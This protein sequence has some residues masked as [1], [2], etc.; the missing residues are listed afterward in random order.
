MPSVATGA[1]TSPSSTR[2]L[3]WAF[4]GSMLPPRLFQKTRWLAALRAPLR[5][6]ID[7]AIVVCGGMEK[8]EASSPSAQVSC[9]LTLTFGPLEWQI[10][11]PAR[12]PSFHGKTYEYRPNELNIG[13]LTVLLGKTSMVPAIEP[14]YLGGM[15][16]VC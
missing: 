4:D 15:A 6:I 5:T 14:C 16:R 10:F 7:M 9:V 8:R 11:V 2:G 3:I 1:S 12:F 13:I